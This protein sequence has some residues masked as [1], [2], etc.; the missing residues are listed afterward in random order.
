MQVYSNKG[1]DPLQRGD[2]HKNVKIG[3]GHLKIFSRTKWPIFTRLGTNYPWGKVFQV[4]FQMKGIS[5]H[6]REIKANK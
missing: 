3:C 6:Q 4:F 5:P 2:N 1:Q